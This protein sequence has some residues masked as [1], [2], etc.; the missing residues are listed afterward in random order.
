MKANNVYHV[1]IV[2]Q[3]T[4]TNMEW[5]IFLHVTRFTCYIFSLASSAGAV[6]YADC[7]SAEG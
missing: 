1:E 3:Q 4:I 2:T 6:E 5:E 7:I